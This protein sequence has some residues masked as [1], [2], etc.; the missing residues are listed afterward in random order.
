MSSVCTR[1]YQTGD[2]YKY[3]KEIKKEASNLKSSVRM[4]AM[5]LKF[6]T[7]YRKYWLYPFRTIW[8]SPNKQ[9]KSLLF[10]VC[11]ED[12]IIQDHKQ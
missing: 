2:E 1:D 10:Y 12:H 5:Q 11:Q 8:T 7:S 3:N 9:K 6:L 4:R